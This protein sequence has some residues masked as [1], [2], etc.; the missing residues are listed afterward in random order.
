MPEDGL[1]QDGHQIEVQ[2]ISDNGHQRRQKKQKRQR[3]Q[4][5]IGD[6]AGQAVLRVAPAGYLIAAGGNGFA[7]PLAQQHQHK[8]APHLHHRQQRGAAWIVVV[9]QRLINRQLNR[10]GLRPAPE[11]QHGGKAGKAEHKD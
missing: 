11:G 4:D 5:K 9:T 10:G 2:P 1:L 3:D 8:A 7:Q 6:A